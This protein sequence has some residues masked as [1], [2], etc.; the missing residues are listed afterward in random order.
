MNT[1]P[2][3]APSE[4]TTQ[5]DPKPAKPRFDPMQLPMVKLFKLVKAMARNADLTNAEACAIHAAMQ[6][7][8]S[9][10]QFAIHLLHRFK[11]RHAK[12]DRDELYADYRQFCV[13][14]KWQPHL[15]RRFERML[16]LEAKMKAAA[17]ADSA[18]DVVTTAT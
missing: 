1:A 2:N 8:D 7:L 17:D 16:R 5:P 15:Q 11:K 12:A 10:G 18:D 4:T 9:V 14:N 13:A 6:E 3:S